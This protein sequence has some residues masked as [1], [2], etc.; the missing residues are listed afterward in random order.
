MSTNDLKTGE[1]AKASGYYKYDGPIS[2]KP[3]CSP[4]PEEQ[5]IPLEK[6]ETAPPVKSCADSAK[7]KFLRSKGK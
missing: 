7:W 1:K 2:G 6:G 4:T 5:I 3:S